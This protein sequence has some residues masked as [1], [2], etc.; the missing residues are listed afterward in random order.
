MYQPSFVALTDTSGAA[1]NGANLILH[2]L[3]ESTQSDINEVEKACKALGAKTVV[4][5]GD[6]AEQ[7]TASAVSVA[8]FESHLQLMD[9]S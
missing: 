8:L 1:R 6:I 7:E 3:G 2:H 9:R 5:P 4:V